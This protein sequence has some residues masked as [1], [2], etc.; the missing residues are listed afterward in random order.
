M[1]KPRAKSDRSHILAAGGILEK[2]TPEG[3]RIAV[4]HRTRYRDR[5]GARGDWVL[6][7]GKCDSGESLEVTALREVREETGCEARI[8][9][10][11][12]PCEYLASGIPKIVMFF[13]MKCVAEHAPPDLAEVRSVRWLIPSDAIDRLTYDTERNVVRQAY[14]KSHL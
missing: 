3:V 11:G 7:K 6:P 9:G 13:L 10:L 8:V 12:F 14:G 5:E 4:V 2:T 1:P